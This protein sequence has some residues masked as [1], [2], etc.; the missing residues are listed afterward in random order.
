MSPAKVEH[1]AI[2]AW[3]YVIGARPRLTLKESVGKSGVAVIGHWY[4]PRARGGKGAPK[5]KSTFTSIRNPDG[6][7]RAGQVNSAVEQEVIKLAQQW[8][9]DLVAGNEPGATKVEH[10]NASEDEERAA[11]TI[12][13]GFALYTGAGGRYH[14][15]S[16]D[17]GDIVRAGQ[18]CVAAL[19]EASTW[20]GIVSM[21]AAETIWRYV[22]KRFAAENAKER[23]GV[24]DT[25][26]QSNARR[27]AAPGSKPSDGSV[28]AKRCVQHFFSCANWLETRAKIP[29]GVCQ[30][31]DNWQAEFRVD[32][33]RLTGRDLDA[34][35]EIEGLR[36]TPDEAKRILVK[37]NDP[38]VDPRVRLHIMCGG[39]SLR[40]GQVTRC[41]RSDLDLNPVGEF[42]MG[43]LRVRGKGKKKG[44]VIDIDPE[45]RAQIIYEITA[46]YLRECEAAFQ[47]SGS[48]GISDYALFTQGRFVDGAIPVRPNRRYLKP[49]SNRGMLE[50]FHELEALA[51]VEHQAGRAWYGLRRLWAD[52]GEE[53]L[54]TKRAKEVLSSHSRG[55][56]MSEQVY[57]SKEDELAIREAS[58][59]RTAIRE[60]LTSGR[61]SDGTALR[62]LVAQTLAVAEPDLLRRV[63]EVLGV[64]DPTRSGTEGES[65][66]ED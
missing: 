5:T 57:Q 15:G 38:R 1:I 60:A 55:S 12:R 4:D 40:A 13:E 28:W 7:P 50:W 19:G 11:R 26:R 52:L 33:G 9:A 53:T 41:M 36:H 51:G 62:G 34:A 3:T 46:G 17:R 32:W 22:Q 61:I 56:R 37:L 63:L 23:P 45:L 43:R 64:P 20:A 24:A 16:T 25:A 21:S 18:D 44:S 29:K 58:R 8:H 30:R 2:G 39:D 47:S 65:H 48:D 42:G 14:P 35:A 31:P 27:I 49:A 54:Q 59:G 66:A 6:H 10:W